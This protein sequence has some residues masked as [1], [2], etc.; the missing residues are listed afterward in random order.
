MGRLESLSNVRGGGGEE[1]EE[2]RHLKG[3]KGES[4]LKERECSDFIKYPVRW[5]ILA[6]YSMF[7]NMQVI[8]SS[9]K[10]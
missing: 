7:A 6:I 5:Y 10:S 4:S 8:S 1:E 2:E 3:I 9:S